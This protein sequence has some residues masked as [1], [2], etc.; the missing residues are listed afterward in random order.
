MEKLKKSQ[1][2]KFEAYS[3]FDSD[4]NKLNLTDLLDVI[5]HLKIS[6]RVTRY[7]D[8]NVRIDNIHDVTLDNGT[9]AL[10]RGM[11][12]IYF[13]VLRLRDD[14]MAKTRLETERLEDV[15]LGDDEFLA[16]DIGCIYDCQLQTVFIQRNFHSLSISGLRECL[17]S[18]YTRLR[19]DN[20]DEDTTQKL[21]LNF[22]PVADAHLIE[23]LARVN[24]Y[25]SISLKFATGVES[26]NHGWIERLLGTLGSA[27]EGLGGTN[28]GVTL[29]AGKTGQPGLTAAEMN[30]LVAE[31]EQ[32]NTLF[33]SAIVRG[34]EGDMPVEVFDLIGGKL[35][36]ENTFSTFTEGD[37]EA[38]RVHLNPKSVEDF[39][40]MAYLHG[41]VGDAQPFRELVIES[42]GVDCEAG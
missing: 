22:Q 5:G 35:C 12:L 36:I 7:F 30:R 15:E 23:K 38:H 13:H 20:G 40:A 24:N 16:E 17:C 11:R 10:N 3:A 8:T 18:F 31:V 32:N 37:G 6:E 1:K 4:G 25:R 19:K 26:H 14:I 42:L 2:V 27:L 34:K 9:I 39:M 41:S 28:L 21:D 33:S 29:T